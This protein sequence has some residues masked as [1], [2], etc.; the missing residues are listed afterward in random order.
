M[1]LPKREILALFRREFDIQKTFKVLPDGFSNKNE[2]SVSRIRFQ[3]ISFSLILLIFG[4]FTYIAFQYR[5]AVINPPLEVYSPKDNSKLY[6]KEVVVFGKT[7]KNASLY[8]N[9][10]PVSLDNKGIFKKNI[11]LFSG[12][13]TITIKAV[14]SLGK[15]TKIERHI[16]ILDR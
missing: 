9:N 12:K 5:Y 11:E 3:E 13:K 8:V 1:G 15:E 2:F 16:E 14:N 6:S 7:D 4:I 10:S